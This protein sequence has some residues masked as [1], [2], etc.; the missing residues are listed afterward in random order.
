MGTALTILDAGDQRHPTPTYDRFRPKLSVDFGQ[1][2]TMSAHWAAQD[3]GAD[4]LRQVVAELDAALENS[5]GTDLARDAARVIAGAWPNTRLEAPAIFAA[6]LQREFAQHPRWAIAA[7]VEELISTRRF[8][9]TISEI[10]EA[11][12][13]ETAHLRKSR[14]VAREALRIAAE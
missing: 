1:S 5:A 9:P 11:I 3:I 10:R 2:I 6:L 4:E 14:M 13:S 7:A 12:L 8:M